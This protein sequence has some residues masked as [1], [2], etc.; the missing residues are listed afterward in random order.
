MLRRSVGSVFLT[1][2]LQLSHTQ[3][4]SMLWTYVIYRQKLCSHRASMMSSWLFLRITVPLLFTP[5]VLFIYSLIRFVSRFGSILCCDKKSQLHGR[6]AGSKNWCRSTVPCCPQHQEH[7]FT[8]CGLHALS[9]QS[10]L[11]HLHMWPCKLDGVPA[12]AAAALINYYSTFLIRA[13]YP[14]TGH[15]CRPC[16][17]DWDC[18]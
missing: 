10:T 9:W 5:G 13:I 1:D 8:D 6:S 12:A 14:D 4:G 11:D 2:L 7:F 15:N 16:V 18:R 17:K 3:S